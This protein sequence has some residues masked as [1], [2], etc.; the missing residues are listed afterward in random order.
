L[1]AIKE[2]HDAL[3]NWRYDPKS[4]LATIGLYYAPATST[5]TYQD[6]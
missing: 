4:R 3:L 1:A 6:P 2:R 5:S